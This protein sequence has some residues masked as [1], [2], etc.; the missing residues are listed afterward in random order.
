MNKR[1][2]ENLKKIKTLGKYTFLPF[3]L[4]V[5]PMGEAPFS[6]FFTFHHLLEHCLN[7]AEFRPNSIC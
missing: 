5:L 2:K 3:S 6:S 7:R 1:C 4:L